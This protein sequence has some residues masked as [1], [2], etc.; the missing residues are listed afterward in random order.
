MGMLRLFV[1]VDAPATVRRLLSEAR[2]RLAASGADVRWEPEEKFHCTLA[3][4]GDTPDELLEPIAAAVGNALRGTG[5][6]PLTYRGIGF[7][8]DRERP[9]TVWGGVGDTDGVLAHVREE[10]VRELEAIGIPRD[11]KPFHAHVTL[12]RIRS[13]RHVRRLTTSAESFTLEQ[14]PVTVREI[15]IVRSVLKPGGSAYTVLRS[16]PL[17]A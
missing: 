1:A 12:G 3:F 9:R 14:S 16:I 11:G 15:V 6:F 4:L 5:P 8:P 7:F 10:I 13:F 17:T 2:D